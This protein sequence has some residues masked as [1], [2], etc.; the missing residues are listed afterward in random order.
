MECECHRVGFVARSLT[1]KRVRAK[2]VLPRADFGGVWRPD[3]SVI[4][5][6]HE[7]PN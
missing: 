3:P 5:A 2:I 7:C 6:Q 1:A 4:S